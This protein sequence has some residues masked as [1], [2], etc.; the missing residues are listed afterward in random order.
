MTT[1]SARPLILTLS[2]EPA[3]AEPLNELRRRHFPSERN[4]L[5]AHVTLFHALPGAHEQS[6][7]ADLEALCSATPAF[8]VTVPRIRHWGKGV[9]AELESPALL[10]FRGELAARWGA[11]L[12]PQDKRTFRPHVTVQ[13]K[14]PEAQAQT[15]YDALAPVW[16]PLSGCATGAELWF[17]AGG[18]WESVAA[19]PF[20]GNLKPNAV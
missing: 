13:N 11:L 12:T 18:P 4:F 17:Y 14:V 5:A 6:V 16:Q 2:L 3:L 1:P 9:F 19:F 20:M 7:R 15:L 8:V 10:E